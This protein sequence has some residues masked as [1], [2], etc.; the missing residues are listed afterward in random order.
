MSEQLPLGQRLRAWR[1]PRGITLRG[2]AAKT[3]ISLS[4]LSRIERGLS[5]PL[6]M[7]AARI[8]ALI[9]T[10]TPPPADW[11]PIGAHPAPD[12][13][14]A[15]QQL[16]AEC[17][18]LA[19]RCHELEQENERLKAAQPSSME[20]VAAATLAGRIGQTGPAAI[21]QEVFH[22]DYD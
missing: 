22:H 14:A 19:Q 20:L 12:W 9:A 13:R 15:A 7:T 17:A 6:S 2:V 4:Q 18:R 5:D 21:A 11:Q 8:E 16:E 1:K 3:G 10:N